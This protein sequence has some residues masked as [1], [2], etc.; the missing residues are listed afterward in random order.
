MDRLRT[1]VIGLDKI[2]HGGLPRGSV[3]I[4]VGPAG[5]GKSIL[6]LQ[7]LLEAVFYKKPA[8][9][10]DTSDLI[11]ALKQTVEEFGR[12][13]AILALIER[14]D[15]YSWRTGTKSPLRFS[16]NPNNLPDLSISLSKTIDELAITAPSNCRLVFDSFSD[17]V[18]HSSDYMKFLPTLRGKLSKA[19][20]TGM[21]LLE[22]GMHD[23]KTI[24]TIEH[25]SD[26]TISLKADESG[27]AMMVR[28]MMATPTEMRWA[29][30]K[31]SRGMEVRAEAFFD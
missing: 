23:N 17:V 30:Y 3:S 8:I 1:G 27:R 26:G 28:R 2:L 20:I 24:S 14:L 18:L 5:S 11:P 7:F 9:L 10:V 16:A 19:G 13:P 22:S 21:I 12:D 4:V 15:C 29:P 6:G 31:I 25:E